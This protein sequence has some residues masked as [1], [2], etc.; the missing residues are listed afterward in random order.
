MRKIALG[1]GK[2]PFVESLFVCNISFPFFWTVRY[3]TPYYTIGNKK[4]FY[5]PLFHIYL[6][7]L[8]CFDI[9]TIRLTKNFQ[10]IFVQL[11]DLLQS[12]II[13]LDVFLISTKNSVIFLKFSFFGNLK[14]AVKYPIARQ[15]VSHFAWIR[16]TTCKQ[17]VF[18][19]Y[20]MNQLQFLMY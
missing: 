18:H 17:A 13:Y 7:I 6:H 15:S 1:S 10:A 12:L 3:N 5:K 14:P 20:L 8:Y 2:K 4:C 11:W 16:K 9:F 19:P